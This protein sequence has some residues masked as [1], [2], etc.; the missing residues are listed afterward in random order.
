MANIIIWITCSV[1]SYYSF[2]YIVKVNDPVWV[3]WQA[4]L[5]GVYCLI[6]PPV[7]II[8]FPTAI[9]MFLNRLDFG[10]GPNSI[11]YWLNEE[12]NW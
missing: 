11:G 6:T 1:I 10:L 4:M 5:L 12:T 7:V 3:R 8:I 9:I 2:K